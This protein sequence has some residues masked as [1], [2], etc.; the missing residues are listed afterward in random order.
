MGINLSRSTPAKLAYWNVDNSH[1]KT[2]L[3]CNDF[4][5]VFLKN[6]ICL[7]GKQRFPIC[8]LTS[9]M[10]LTARAR[11]GQS[12]GA[13]NSNWV[14]HTVAGTQVF[15]PSSVAYQSTHEQETAWDS[16][17]L[18]F[19]SDT[20]MYLIGRHPEQHSN[21]QTPTPDFLQ[22]SVEILRLLGFIYLF[23]KYF[24]PVLNTLLCAKDTCCMRWVSQNPL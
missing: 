24:L 1:F 4:K 17:E 19:R 2:L 3:T 11:P 14:S 23:N 5:L 15:E 21:C 8:Q 13:G 22:S 6:V 20:S 16:E 9:K 7:K 12:R 10:N 18:V